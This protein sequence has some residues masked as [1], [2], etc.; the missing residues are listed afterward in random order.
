MKGLAGQKVTATYQG[1]G[2]RL[3]FSKNLGGNKKVKDPAG[4]GA[5]KTHGAPSKKVMTKLGC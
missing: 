3:P 4:P 5:G 2:E 1:K